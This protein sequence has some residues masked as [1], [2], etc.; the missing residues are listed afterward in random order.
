[1]LSDDRL[2]VDNLSRVTEAFCA[3]CSP[4]DQPFRVVVHK[5]QAQSEQQIFMPLNTIQPQRY[6][7]V[8]SD[9]SDGIVEQLDTGDLY[10]L[11]LKTTGAWLGADK[12]E[13]YLM[14][15]Q[16]SAH[17]AVCRANGFDVKGVLLFLVQFSKLPIPDTTKCK[18]HK[19]PKKD[20]WPSHLRFQRYFIQRSDE[21]LAQWAREAEAAAYRY[22]D[23]I[24]RFNG[25][26]TGEPGWRGIRMQGL[27]NGTCKDCHLKSFCLSDRRNSASIVTRQVTD[28]TIVRS[29][30][31]EE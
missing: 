14:D 3:Q 24:E 16:F 30:V 29:G 19:I 1:M 27:F 22:A 7:V 9:K 15:G 23:T 26:F 21:Q 2:H 11:E 10:S 12:A 28:S 18:E 25:S 5:G 20:C 17:T 6:N 4:S 13:D 31:Y 8:M